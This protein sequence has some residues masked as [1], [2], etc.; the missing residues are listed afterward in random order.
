MTF[1]RLIQVAL[2]L[3][4]LG[5]ASASPVLISPAGEVTVDGQRRVLRTPAQV[6]DGALLVPLQETAALLGRPAQV[7]GTLFQA[8]RLV[9]QTSNR[10]MTIDGV[11]YAGKLVLTPGGD[12]L[13]EARLLAY[14]LDAPLT[15]QAGGVLVFSRPTGSV[16]VPAPQPAAPPAQGATVPAPAG[17]RPEARFATN[18][19]VYAPGE[20]VTYT[21]FSFDPDGLNLARKWE[22]QQDVFFTPGE[23]QITLMV[24]NTKGM[25]SAP[26]TRTIRVEGAPVNTPLS[27]ALRHT[28]VGATFADTRN[29]AYPAAAATM[30][31][32]P[33]FPLLFSDSP[34]APTQSGVLYRDRA[35]GRVRVV[36]YHLN[37]LPRPARLFVLAR[38]TTA[39]TSVEVQREGSAGGT[40]LESVLGQVSVLDFLTSAG[41]ARQLL[42]PQAPTA[43]YISPLLTPEQGATALLDLNISGEAEISVV[44]LEDG[45]Q[46]TNDTLAALPVLPPDGKHQRGTF[47]QAVRRLTVPVGGAPVQVPLGDAVS[48]LPLLG[49]DALTGTPQRLSGNYGLLY[50]LTVENTVPG[51]SV[52]I[53]FAPRGGV[54]RGGV[55][56]DDGLDRQVLRIP[57]SGVLTNGDQPLL[58]WRSAARTVRLSFLPAGGSFLPVSLVLYPLSGDA[59]P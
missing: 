27:F 11:P 59:R 12:P 5:P 41:R 14:A 13:V 28:P 40:R 33:S 3:A 51:N 24:T 46:P 36:A 18:K 34:E 54:Y 43:L 15:V 57:G 4:L 47:P 7:S 29:P 26:Y 42:D 32:G 8:G 10:S 19:A 1:A 17:G 21:D 9:V 52:V 44:M 16:P 53:A 39:N 56:L 37:R 50:E 58:L 22:G 35:A 38:P 30:T 31:P 6:V 20:R 45:R 23:H 2:L 49:T 55:V 25:V 48:D